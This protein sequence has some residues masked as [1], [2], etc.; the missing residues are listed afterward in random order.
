[1]AFE[2]VLYCGPCDFKHTGCIE[3]LCFNVHRSLKVSRNHNV[4]IIE[5]HSALHTVMLDLVET[6]RCDQHDKPS[7]YICLLH[8]EIVCVKCI[9][10]K[11][12]Q[13]TGWL[14]ISEV[15]DGVKSSVENQTIKQDLEGMIRNVQELIENHEKERIYTQNVCKTLKGE[16]SILVQSIIQK[17]KDLEAEFVKTVDVQHQEISDNISSLTIELKGKLQ[18]VKMMK[19]KMNG[20]EVMRQTLNFFW[21]SVKL[22]KN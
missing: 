22:P 19:E 4:I 21:A 1:M 2:K 15:A 3:A 7:K 20:I 14:T 11:H 10:I 5:D 18:K 17:V 16:A 9:Q 13:C 12:S 8:D 6:Q